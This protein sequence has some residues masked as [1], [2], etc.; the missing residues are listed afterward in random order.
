MQLGNLVDRLLERNQSVLFLD[1]CTLLDV[2]RAP[3]RNNMPCMETAIR[4]AAEVIAGT[5]SVS[6]VLPSLFSR[7]WNDNVDNVTKELTAWLHR[8]RQ[9]S[10][11]LSSLHQCLYQGPLSI[12]DVT[13]YGFEQ[14]VQ[15]ICDRIIANSETVTRSSESERLAVRRVITRRAPAS[16]GKQELKDCINFEEF[17]E[18]GAELRKRGMAKR[19][20]FASS[21]TNDY[22][23]ASHPRLEIVDDL[24]VI[25]AEFAVSLP[26]GYS[27]A[28]R[29]S[30]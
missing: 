26:H 28:S 14:S 9:Q 24:N 3:F 4:V 10:E 7:E 17:L 2:I 25:A 12:P 15:Q 29:L 27:L 11:V 6:L 20:V 8:H 1:V 13:A 21:N 5:L 23:E 19:I 22:C 18:L 30:T 16:H